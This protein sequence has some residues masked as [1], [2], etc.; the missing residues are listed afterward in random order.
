[1]SPRLKMRIEKK[2]RTMVSLHKL[3]L[4][5]FEKTSCKGLKPR[6]S[7][8]PSFGVYSEE[9]D[10]YFRCICKNNEGNIVEIFAMMAVF[11][12]YFL[13]FEELIDKRIE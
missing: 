8:N 6:H 9:R 7:L 2:L 10:I 3:E 5:S 11:L 1:M 4:I 12:G 13:F